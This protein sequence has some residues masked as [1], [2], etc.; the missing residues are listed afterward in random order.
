M[1]FHLDAKDRYIPFN[2]KT[3]GHS[4]RPPHPGSLLPIGAAVY[5]LVAVLPFA[6]PPVV[7]AL[8]ELLPPPSLA[9]ALAGMAPSLAAFAGALAGSSA[10]GYQE[11][12]ESVCVARW[13]KGTHGTGTR[14]SGARSETRASALFLRHIEWF[15]VWVIRRGVLAL[16]SRLL[17]PLLNDPLKLFLSLLIYPKTGCSAREN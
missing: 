17:R 5:F 10:L 6:A 16:A 11:R 1:K 12:V 4:R 14:I 15:L 9:G 2:P 3:H 8:P 7:G 13:G